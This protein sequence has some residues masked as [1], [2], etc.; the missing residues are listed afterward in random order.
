MKNE[1]RSLFCVMIVDSSSSM[2]DV[3]RTDSYYTRVVTKGFGL[4]WKYLIVS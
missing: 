1:Q 4:G 3:R 2:F